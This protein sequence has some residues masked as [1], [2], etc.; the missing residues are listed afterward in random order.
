MTLMTIAHWLVAS[1]RSSVEVGATRKLTN[2]FSP[3]VASPLSPLCLLF[4]CSIF[5]FFSCCL[6]SILIFYLSA[7][8]PPVLF[9]PCR[10]FLL[11][12]FSLHHLSFLLS[13]FP[14]PVFVFVFVLVSLFVLVSPILWSVS[15][16]LHFILTHLPQ[17][18]E[19]TK[20]L[21]LA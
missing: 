6:S 8:F 3:H 5:L 12:S 4:S 16:L 7:A 21:M 2:D 17:E 1:A 19:M 18:P 10:L 14:P 9:P 13:F 20:Y 15:S 11:A